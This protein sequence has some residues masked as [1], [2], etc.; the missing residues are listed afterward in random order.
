MARKKPVKSL[1]SNPLAKSYS[2]R[3]TIDPVQN[4]NERL[5]R[6]VQNTFFKP[7]LYEQQCVRKQPI[8]EL[9]V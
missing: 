7:S 9:P 3:P 4:L 2:N 8:P 5:V 1:E 6:E